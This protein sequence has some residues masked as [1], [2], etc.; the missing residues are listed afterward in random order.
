MLCI[1]TRMEMGARENA[2]S[3]NAGLLHRAERMY[4]RTL[5]PRKALR[6]DAWLPTARLWVPRPSTS[7]LPFRPQ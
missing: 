5:L 1:G 7:V 6:G 4:G 2:L 3:C